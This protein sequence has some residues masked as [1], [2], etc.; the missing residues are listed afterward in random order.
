[1]QNAVTAFM[2]FTSKGHISTQQSTRAFS[3]AQ[4]VERIDKHLS[5]PHV[6]FIWEATARGAHARTRTHQRVPNV[7]LALYNTSDSSLNITDYASISLPYR[8]GWG[9]Q[10]S[11]AR[12]GKGLSLQDHTQKGFYFI[13]TG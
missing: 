12:R 10:R 13:S 9:G 5:G 4:P 6:Y 3:Q 8:L 11:A 7:L 1:M 2:P